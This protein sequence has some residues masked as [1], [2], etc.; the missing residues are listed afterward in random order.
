MEYVKIVVHCHTGYCGMDSWD[1]YEVP[2]SST[3]QERDDLAWECALENAASYGI[4]PTSDRPD[5]EGPED[6]DEEPDS[7]S[8]SDNIEGSWYLYDADEHDGYR[9]GCDNSWQRAL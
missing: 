6:F 5:D 1:F 2:A 3:D 4:Y 9:V 7:D 8:Y